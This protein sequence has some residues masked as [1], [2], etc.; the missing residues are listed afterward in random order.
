SL[1]NRALS[2][3]ELQSIYNESSAGKCPPP[4]APNCVPAPAGLISWWPLE[5]N[6]N[7]VADGNPG[8]VTGSAAFVAGEVGLGLNCTGV[9]QGVTVSNSP[10]LN[11]GPGVDFSIECWVKPVVASTSF[12]VMDLVD[13]RVTPNDS[14]SIGYALSLSNGKLACQMSDSISNPF[15]I[16]GP[17]G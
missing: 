15:L 16:A 1:Y 10:S 14:S 4:P 2:L 8:T 7:D 9:P 3:T 11:F 13:K 12:G 6:A 5:G 17:A